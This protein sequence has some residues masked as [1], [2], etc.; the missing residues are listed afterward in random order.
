MTVVLTHLFKLLSLFP[1]IFAVFYSFIF[2]LWQVMVKILFWKWQTYAIL[3][4]ENFESWWNDCH[5]YWMKF[6]KPNFIKIGHIFTEIRRFN[7]FKMATVRHLGF[8]KFAVF[9][10]IFFRHAILLHLVKICRILII[11]RSLAE[12]SVKTI[13]KMAALCCLESK[14]NFVT[15][16]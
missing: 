15:W 13:F 16:L 3:N 6:C 7:I 14:K 5:L 10:T 11:R 1:F 8:S 12:L 4:F 9:V 2:T